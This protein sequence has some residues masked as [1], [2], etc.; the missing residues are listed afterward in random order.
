MKVQNIIMQQRIPT[1]KRSI[2]LQKMQQDQSRMYLV[3]KGQSRMNKTLKIP[4]DTAVLI[5]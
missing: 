3:S 1:T 4:A 2:L 5:G